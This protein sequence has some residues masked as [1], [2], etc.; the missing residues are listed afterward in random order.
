M[1][2]APPRAGQRSPGSHHMPP[3]RR[4]DAAADSSPSHLRES[5]RFGRATH[6]F[7]L[8]VGSFLG[9]RVALPTVRLG[10]GKEVARLATGESRLVSAYPPEQINGLTMEAL[11]N[12]EL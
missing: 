1:S 3:S 9:K 11:S 6:R 8:S 5:F 7:G 4:R 10:L 2:V 12:V